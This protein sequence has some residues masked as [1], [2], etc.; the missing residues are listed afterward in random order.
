[1]GKIVRNITAKL[2]QLRNK[3]S[4]HT[5]TPRLSPHIMYGFLEVCVSTILKIAVFVWTLMM[6]ADSQGRWYSQIVLFI[7]QNIGRL[8]VTW[9][10]ECSEYPVC[11]KL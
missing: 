1:M 8:C 9:A 3:L 5:I 6:L 4:R 2:T 7:E 10:I 11:F